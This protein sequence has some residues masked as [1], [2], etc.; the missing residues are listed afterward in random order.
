MDDYEDTEESDQGAPIYDEDPNW[1]LEDVDEAYI[2]LGDDC[3]DKKKNNK[4]WVL[5][6]SVIILKLMSG[7]STRE[8]QMRAILRFSCCSSLI[9]TII[10]FKH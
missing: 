2:K 9:N 3:D 1:T 5:L 7:L 4:S 8:D 10:T 6:Q